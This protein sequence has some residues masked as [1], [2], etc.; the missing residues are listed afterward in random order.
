MPRSDASAFA[1]TYA[2]TY[3]DTDS[4][5]DSEPDPIRYAN[6]DT[7]AVSQSPGDRWEYGNVALSGPGF[8]V[9]RPYDRRRNTAHKSQ[10]RRLYPRHKHSAEQISAGRRHSDFCKCRGR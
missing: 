1:D 9:G 2:D 4:N 3:A 7:D 10:R 6:S 5:T 8:R